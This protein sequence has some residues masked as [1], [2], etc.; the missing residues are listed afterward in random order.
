MKDIWDLASEGWDLID[1]AKKG[2]DRAEI[3]LDHDEF[4]VAR[5]HLRDAK[6][7]METIMAEAMKETPNV[8]AKV[9]RSGHPDLVNSVTLHQSSN[10]GLILENLPEVMPDDIP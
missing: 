9:V 1:K 10:L 6:E 7:L 3:N 8:Y 2:L 4:S 5:T